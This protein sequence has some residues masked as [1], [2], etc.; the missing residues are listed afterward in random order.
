MIGLIVLL[1]R[2]GLVELYLYSL[3]IVLCSSLSAMMFIID[4]FSLD[5]FGNTVSVVVVCVRNKIFY[6]HLPAELN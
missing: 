2:S 5:Y 3:L 1:K 6:L 4:S